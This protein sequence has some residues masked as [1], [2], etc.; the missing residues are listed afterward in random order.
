M[1]IFIGVASSFL[2]LPPHKVIRSDGTLVKLKASTK[3]HEEVLGVL[4][5]LMDWRMLGMDSMIS[6]RLYSLI[7][8]YR[9]ARADVLCL[10]L[11]LRLPKRGQHCAF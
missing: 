5:L 1:I 8:L 3:L 2:V 4:R 7:R 6:V 9:S 10:E 11:L